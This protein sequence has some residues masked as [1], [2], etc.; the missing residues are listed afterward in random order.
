MSTEGNENQQNMRQTQSWESVQNALGLIRVKAGNEKELK[1]TTLLHH[2]YNVETLQYAYLALKR[3]AAP[4]VDGM[5]WEVYGENLQERLQDLSKRLKGGGYRAKPV[6][7]VFIP[8]PDGTKRPLGVT[9]LEDKIV[10]R[11]VVEVLNAI[12][13][14]DFKGFSYGFRP[15]RSQ[16]QALDALY[17]AITKEKVNWILDADIRDFFGSIHPEKLL[18]FIERRIGDRRVIRLIQKWLKAGVLEDGELEFTENGTPQGACI[19]PLLANVYLHYVYDEWTH[20]WRNQRAEGDMIVI[21]FADDTIV[22]FQQET[23]AVSYLA[24]LRENLST[25]GLELHPEKTRLIEFG[26]YAEERRARKGKGKP[27]AFIFLGFTHICSTKKGGEFEVKRQTAGK[28]MC[29]KLAEI[30]SELRRRINEPVAQVGE[31]LSRVLTGHTSTTQYRETSVQCAR[32]ATMSR[33]FGF[34]F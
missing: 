33:D 13:E 27:D 7:R 28:K 19:S 34:A 15:G 21:R 8:K 4:G 16:H 5:K 6:R 22:G 12:Y 2:I 30:T 18:T 26:R 10:Q 3:D 25:F 29:A 11:A 31:W 17:V 14:V 32:Y 9:S 1:F 20:E 24:D 23:D